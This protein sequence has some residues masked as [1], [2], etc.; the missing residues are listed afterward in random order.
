MLSFH[1]RWA[2]WRPA[3]LGHSE[4]ARYLLDFMGCS[5]GVCWMAY[6]WYP[7]RGA[8][9]A[10]EASGFVAPVSGGPASTGM[11]LVAPEVEA[12]GNRVLKRFV[13]VDSKVK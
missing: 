2:H 5:Y 3:S 9:S 12:Q 10:E 6:S 13:I 4:L 7:L 1:P 11:I 8:R